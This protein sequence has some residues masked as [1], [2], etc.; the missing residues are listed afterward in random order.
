M[1]PLI[2]PGRTG[3]APAEE[4]EN[5]FWISYAD[6]MT[7]LMVLFLVVMAVALLAVTRTV[8]ER[9]KREGFWPKDLSVGE[10]GHDI[11]LRSTPRPAP[12]CWTWWWRRRCSR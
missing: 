3:K 1:N 10:A 8:S 5:P 12:T 9:E 11:G 4:A 2:P 7:A 6:L